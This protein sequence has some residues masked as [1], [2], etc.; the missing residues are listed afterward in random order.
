MSALSLIT[1]GALA[2]TAASVPAAFAV[3][4][5]G[6]RV[7]SANQAADDS[8][9]TI[10]VRLAQ[11]GG[12]QDSRY[13]EAKKRIGDAVAQARPGATIRDV[14]DYHHVFQGFAIKAP[15]STLAA[16]KAT[17]GVVG[18]FVEGRHALVNDIDFW[19]IHGGEDSD[20]SPALG[21]ASRMTRASL[22]ALAGAGQVV[23]VIDTRFDT[24]HEAFSGQMDAATLRLTK[25]GAESLVSGLGAGR[26][27]AWVS[28]KIP[29]A[30]DYGDGDADVI[31]SGEDGRETW[32]AYTQG[33][34][35]AAL[36]AANGSAFTGAAPGAQLIVA[37]VTED[38]RETATDSALL[39]ALDDAAVL[40][41]DVLTVS[42]ATIEGM[43]SDSEALYAHVYQNLSAAGITVNAPAG[44][45][46]GTGYASDP[47]NG[48][49]AF[50]ASYSSTLAVAS[51]NEQEIMGA[52]TFGDRRIGYRTITRM[53]QGEAPGFESLGEGT[54][55]VVYAGNGTAADLE[56]YLGSN[57]GDLSRT[58]IL[59]DWGGTDDRGRAV[60]LKHQ[61]RNL[62]SLTSKPAGL[63]VAH[64]TDT[65]TPKKADVNRWFSV[66]AG[67]ITKSDGEALREAIAASESG[68]VEV[69][70]SRSATLAVP[71]TVEVSE[72]SSSGATSDLRLK[73][74]LAAPGG[75][76]L[77]ATPGN[78][79]DRQP[80][81]A[82]AAGQ[83]A[84][85]A[86]L[87]RQRMATDPAFA[88]TS[89]AEKSALVSNFLMG[90]ARPL[91]DATRNDGTFY[92]PRRVGAG[93]VDALAATT[94]PVYPT[95]VGAPDPSRPKADLGDGTQGW[96]FQVSLTNVSDTARTYRVAGQALSEDVESGL[97]TQHS[98]N[99]AGAGI[100]LTFSADTVTVPASSS[101][102]VTVT[103]T[104]Q[105]A[106]ASHANATTPNGTFIDGAVTFTST[107]GQPDLTVPY[108]G[109]YGSWGAANVFDQQ[110]PNNHKVGY[111]STVAHG[112]MPFGQSNPF[113]E[114]DAR[115]ADGIDP[116]R[117]VISRSTQEQA[118]RSIGTETVL[119]RA[120]PSLTFTLT[121]EAGDALRSY[122][123]DRSDK[124]VYDEHW[125]A[126]HNVEFMSPGCQPR[127]D[128]YDADGNELPDGRYTVTIEAPNYGPSSRTHQTSYSFWLDTVAP[129]VSN[130]SI[131]GEGNARTLSFDL[132][133]SSPIAGYGFSSA[134]DGE[135][136]LWRVEDAPNVRADD[137]LFHQHYEVRLSEVA[138]ALGEEPA[139]LYLQAWDWPANKGSA[140]VV[141][142]PVSMTSLSVS[143]Q[144][145]TMMIGETVTVRAA[146]RPDDANVTDVVWSSSN[147]AVATV[148]QD[149]VI[150]A[151]GAGEATITVSDP[152]QPSVSA[153]VT[154]RV[155]APAPAHKAGTW[156]WDIHGWWYQFEDGSYPSDTTLELDGVT[157]RLDE[158]GYMRTGWVSERGVWYYHHVSGAQ[159]KGWVLDG[160]HWYYMDPDT[161]AMVTGWLQVGG[162]WYYLSPSNGAMVTGWFKDG[163]HWFYLHHGS[164]A[165][166]TGWVRIYLKWYQ[167]NDAGQLVG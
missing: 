91:V 152:T 70:V 151:V 75:R 72:F 149:G 166:A 156:L 21:S 73:P 129:M 41:P 106:F 47:D 150:S 112:V 37:K 80:G 74:E 105:D 77:S 27:G 119:L 104:P 153:A 58:I 55:R 50:P 144:A 121:N 101:A 154:I 66:R 160:L 26:G 87:V 131:A 53:N 20:D 67:T 34:H 2:L 139:T 141:V 142:T 79:Y 39:A 92:S 76:V 16:I 146:H 11:E 51:V 136:T 5:N 38:G 59:E 147:E 85:I 132:T 124:S 125:R 86:T 81:T 54:Y 108:M 134:Q 15:S 143:P 130:V 155:S 14:R 133:D 97:F 83:V 157:Y 63:M 118:R 31:G 165:M 40:A 8:A 61:L 29:F 18:A 122:T 25:D 3:D 109:F 94:S 62:K 117:V 44:N 88:G 145:A 96:T 123:C 78:N 36:A 100:D 137:G 161:G 22:S 71:A 98:T 89:A 167:F 120:V 148:G 163:D 52:V 13:A 107:D 46:G 102:T 159:A 49:L 24:S 90:T 45:E 82:Q 126:S 158:N 9:V 32:G 42:F 60:E 56:K 28:D 93:L 4:A 84:G 103:V 135:L 64:V 23:E 111:G 140:A 110:W 128:G 113:Q 17:P 115:M 116:D 30:Y 1:T 95:V 68:Y 12:D 162:T 6:A 19:G 48:M 164:G 7:S 114:E 138:Q 99:W 69:T 57:Y 127:F 10:I 33:T 43:S 65:S 35:V